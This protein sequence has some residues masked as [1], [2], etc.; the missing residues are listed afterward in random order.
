M[1]KNLL[2]LGNILTILFVLICLFAIYPDTILN[3]GI[4][5]TSFIF[6]QSLSRPLW[7]IAIGWLFFLCMTNRAGIINKILSWPI[8]IP[9][10]RLNYATYLTHL[11]LIFIMI[12]N[13]RIPFYYQPHLVINNFVVHIF[14]SYITAIL[15]VIFIETPFFIIEKKLFKR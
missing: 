13:Q 11:T 4:D 14:F 1:N 15:V 8:W 9:L 7:S 3:P 12:T 5:R 10:A 6:Y 2:I